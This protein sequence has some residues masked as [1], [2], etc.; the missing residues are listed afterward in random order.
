MV[1]PFDDPRTEIRTCSADGAAGKGHGER[2]I[3]GGLGRRMVM[4]FSR[5]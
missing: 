4:D 3:I 1:G 2:P 5:Q